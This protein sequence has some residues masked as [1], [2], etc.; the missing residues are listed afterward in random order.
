MSAILIQQVY[1][2]QP[3]ADDYVPLLELTRARNEEYCRLHNF[4]YQC[5]VGSVSEKY[6]DVKDGGWVKV[7]LIKLAL[8][9]EYEHVIWLDADAMIKDMSTDLREGCPPRG[10]GACWMRIPQLNHWNVGV[11]YVRNAPD[12]VKF[13][14][15]WLAEYPGVDRWREQGVF[16]ALAM[17]SKVVQTISDRWNSTFNYSMVPDAVV[18][19]Y[20]GAGTTKQRFELMKSTLEYISPKKAEQDARGAREVA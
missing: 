19:G 8:V 3:E 6:A 4:D 13:I 14:D 15:D 17:K 20:H 18:L 16:N 1:A 12:V 11:L 10:I 7:E 9:K 5:L 2:G